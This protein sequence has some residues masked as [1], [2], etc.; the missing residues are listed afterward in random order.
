MTASTGLGTSYWFPFATAVILGTMMLAHHGHAAPPD[1]PVTS[2]AS[3]APKPADLDMDGFLDRL[4]IAESGGR[5]DVRNPRS[6]ALG[7]YQFIESTW[8]DLT[9][10]LFAAE[11]QGKTPAQ[12][13]ALRADRA[14]ARKAA[15]A[16]TLESAATLKSNGL[17]AT[18]PRLRLAFLLGPQGAV[19][20][21]QSPPQ[22]RVTA[23]LG[24]KVA[25]AN[26][27]MYGL[28][29]E[30]LIARAAHDLAVPLATQAGVASGDVTTLANASK[31]APR[32]VVRC[33]LALMSCRRWQALAIARATAISPSRKK[34]A[35]RGR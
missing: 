35:V 17:D 12:V 13:L 25:N 2:T 32:V 27:F 28:T 23:L 6:S 10:R 24:P 22:M 33:N 20:V 19:R 14:L 16:Y 15:Q 31:A 30:G 21:L 29:A 1:L 5:L 8:L 26:P 7:P 3:T 11:T 9:R 34:V 4:M 18:F